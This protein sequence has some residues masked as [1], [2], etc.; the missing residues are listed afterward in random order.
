MQP[1]VHLGHI[2]FAA[3]APAR[4]DT[5]SSSTTS[6][7]P[8]RISAASSLLAPVV[9][10]S[11]SSRR[12]SPSL[13]IPSTLLP[14][15]WSWLN[16]MRNGL[17]VTFDPPELQWLWALSCCGYLAWF[18]F[19]QWRTDRRSELRPQA[20]Y[21]WEL[22]NENAKRAFPTILAVWA[23]AVYLAHHSLEAATNDFAVFVAGITVGQAVATWCL[24]CRP[25]GD[26]N[27]L[28]QLSMLPC[29]IALLTLA[30][31]GD[32]HWRTGSSYRGAARWVGAWH[33]VNR[34]GL[35]MGTGIVIAVGLA[36]W[37]LEFA[38]IAPV[39]G[40]QK[41][42]LGARCKRWRWFPAVL[43]LAAAGMMAVRLVQTFSRGSWL[44]TL[45]GLGCLAYSW[46]KMPLDKPA[47][48]QWARRNL[49]SLMVVGLSVG[50]LL[51]WN[52][53]QTE[54]RIVRR[55]FSAAN[56]ND[57]AWRNR[58]AA[59]EGALQIM[60]DRPLL[61]LGWDTPKLVYDNL[62]QPAKLAEGK[63]L[64]LNDYFTLGM[65]LGVPALA[66]FAAYVWLS[67]TDIPSYKIQ[68]DNAA[69]FPLLTSSW[70]RATCRAGVTVMLVGFWFE[71]A[72][73]FM[74]TGVLFWTLLELGRQDTEAFR[75]PMSDANVG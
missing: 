3:D 62:Y 44:G 33:D 5:A 35:M 24:T 10:R 56:Q 11:S 29:I 73:C 9:M 28:I 52:Y 6:P 45:L 41:A 30:T 50:M 26:D 2:P 15:P 71:R 49:L 58:M 47:W 74:G 64:E 7:S 40:R 23:T 4:R 17:F 38:T 69:I 37:C 63:A 70:L 54:E 19:F 48:I 21:K 67:L 61:G 68:Q 72:L 14:V 42:K 18:A 65:S 16:E 13:K 32:P 39:F 57:F 60:A 1:Y 36:V 59:Y 20:I 43:L 53:R 8:L 66:C 51:F 34:S 25:S 12:R 31:L 27:G 46:W 75:R 55:A 22:F